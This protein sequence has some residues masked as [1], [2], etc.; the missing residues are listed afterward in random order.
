MEILLVYMMVH[1]NNPSSS[2]GP[3]VSNRIFSSTE[4]CEDFVNTLAGA[5]ALKD[6]RFKF[7]SED[8]IIFH[9]GC[10]TPFEYELYKEGL[11]TA[12]KDA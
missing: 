7:V 5:D 9:G 1:M 2:V 3:Q 12:P 8:G 6:N 4:E 11:T 10:M